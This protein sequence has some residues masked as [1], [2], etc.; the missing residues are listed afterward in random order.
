MTLHHQTLATLAA[1]LRRVGRARAAPASSRRSSPRIRDDFQRLLVADG[2]VAGLAYFRDDGRVEHL[3]HPRD[4]E[5]GIALQP[6]AD[7][8]RDPRGSLHAASRREHHVELIRRHLLAADGARLFDRPLPYRGGVPAALPARGDQHASSGARSASCTPTRT[9]ATRRRWRTC[10]DAE[11]FFLALRQANPVGPARGGAERAAAPGQL[12]H[13]EL[14]R[15]V[16]RTATRRPRATT[17]CGRARSRSKAAGASTRAARES[18]CGSCASACSACASR[19]PGSA[20]TRCCRARS[21]ACA[22][23]VG[24][25]GPHGR[26]ALPRRRA[27]LRPAGATAERRGAAVRRAM[28]NPY[29]QGGAQVSMDGVP[30]A[31]ARRRQH[32]SLVEL[33]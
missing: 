10:G 27:G 33:G 16:S 15:G 20:S 26:A 32:G 6:A 21:T 30:R 28:Q 29:R 25:R 1:A 12:L 31:A 23:R 14:R 9:S 22:P 5:T 13:V 2:V 11:A 4:R 17:R 19:A 24:D 3:L 18:R 7:D 8:P